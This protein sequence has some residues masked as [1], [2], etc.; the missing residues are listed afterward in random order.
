LKIGKAI[1]ARRLL[2]LVGASLRWVYGSIWRSIFNQQKFTFREYL[3]G[4]NKPK[5]WFDEKGHRL[6]NVI[7]A[8]G[9]L[10]VVVVIL[11][12]INLLG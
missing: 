1:T 2:N 5:G 10:F 9:F 11:I 7:V 8:F 6:S 12:K 3:Y 4:P